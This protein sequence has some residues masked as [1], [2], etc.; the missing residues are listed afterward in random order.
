MNTRVLIILSLLV[1][2]GAVLHAI[3]PG[4]VYGVKPDMML[5]MMFLG[6]MLFPRMKYVVLVAIV[7]GV[8]SALTTMA[9]GGQIA[10]MIDKPITALLFFGLF[11]L[12]K[13]RIS[14]NVSAPALTAIGTMISGTVFLGSALYIVGLMEGAF[15]VLFLTVVLPTAAI[16][17]VL[18]AVVY[19]IV[20]KIIKRSQPLTIS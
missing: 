19:P 2:I 7:T 14:L 20:Q 16:N 17:T 18:M 9:P 6:I 10:N 13:D 11:V 4:I 5:T 8:I 15:P 3:V 1:G 12:I